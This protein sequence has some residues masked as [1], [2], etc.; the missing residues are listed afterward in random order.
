MFENQ[1]P[2]FPDFARNHPLPPC[3]S[4]WSN[5]APE[6][7]P[8]KGDPPQGW[9]LSFMLTQEPGMTGRGK[10]TSWWAGIANLFWWCDR[11]KGVAG[12]I[13]SQVLP[14]G[15]PI[16]MGQWFACEKAVYDSLAWLV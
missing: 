4:E 16:V 1:I 14:F 7:Y 12:M 6:L 3:K 8:E 10:G 11:E 5:P 13:A 9:G 15:D 2:E